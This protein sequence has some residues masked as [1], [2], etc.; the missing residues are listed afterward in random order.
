MGN[1]LRKQAPLN[2]PVD[3]GAT[4][5]RAHVQSPASIEY[6]PKMVM[7]LIANR[8]IAPF[9]E[10]K[11]DCSPSPPADS[12][13]TASAPALAPQSRAEASSSRRKL[14]KSEEQQRKQA[15]ACEY[16]QQNWSSECPICLLYFPLNINKTKCCR[17]NMCTKC[18]VSLK[19][20]PSGRVLSCPFC[21]ARN[22]STQYHTPLYIWTERHEPS[23]LSAIKV[24]TVAAESIRPYRVPPRPVRRAV[25]QGYY[26]RSGGGGTRAQRYGQHAGPPFAT[27][28]GGG[29]GLSSQG[30]A[31]PVGSL[32]LYDRY[33]R[34]TGYIPSGH[35]VGRPYHHQPLPYGNEAYRGWE[36]HHIYRSALLDY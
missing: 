11:S 1:S 13:S 12:G 36:T 9:Y 28:G 2:G 33:G 18:F 31:V 8:K 20:P 24:P 25:P 32:V 21:N 14:K 17:Q 29:R 34:A 6:D 3:G 16:T 23:K 19:R 15:D 22:F 27:V 7:K 26:Y 4:Y 30:G 10:G 5:V 35:G